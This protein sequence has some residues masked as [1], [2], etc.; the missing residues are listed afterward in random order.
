MLQN[1]APGTA[2]RWSAVAALFAAGAA[3]A[4]PPHRQAL[5]KYYGVHLAQSLHQCATCHLSKDEV[6]DP[7]EYDP[8][9]PPH[10]VFGERLARLGEEFET[11]GKPTDVAL[12][13]E[14]VANEDADGDGVPNEIEI[15]LGR[16]AGRP[17]PPPEK[18]AIEE[19]L[20]KQ[21]QLRERS[22]AYRW[23]P[24]RRVERPAIP[25][26]GAQG[27]WAANPIDAFIAEGYAAHGLAP[28]PPAPRHVLIRRAYLDL[29]GLPPTAEEVQSFAA[30]PSPDAFDRT[31]DRL[32]ASPAH[33]ERWGRH[34]MDVWRYSDW[35]GWTD[36]GQIRDSQPH[37]WRWRDWIIESLNADKG[38]D[39]MVREM[40]AGDELAPEDPAALA[41]TGFLVRNYKM[42]SRETWLQDAVE[43]TGKAFLGLTL[44]CARCHD[45]VYDPIAQEEYFQFR[46]IFEPHN[47]RLDRVPGQPD[48]KLD[49]LPRV[50]DAEPAAKTYVFVRG[51]DRNPDQ[52]R[53][54]PPGPPSCVQGGAFEVAAVPLPT[55]AYYPGLDSFVAQETLAAARARVADAQAKLT[56]AQQASSGN[57]QAESLEA[58]D[59]RAAETELASLEARLAADRVKHRAPDSAELAELSAAAARA[60]HAAQL[61]AKERDLAGA[62]RALA[63]LQQAS[64]VDEG[65]VAEA[66]K[67]RDAAAAERDRAA[68][69]APGESYSSVGPVYP[70]SSTGRRAALARWLTGRENPLAARV[71]VNHLWR[72]HFGQAI[73]AST[74]DFGQNGSPPSHP[75][76]LD[77]LAA[78]FMESSAPAASGP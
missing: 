3:F 29:V 74:F 44:N 37:I 62:E 69:Q 42:L 73:V 75:A 31:V 70:S 71:A 43:H 50:Y 48:P 36:G 38:Y 41:A 57:E 51:D 52:S 58:L 78:E 40:L 7:E 9:A 23:A 56:A 54:I 49:G 63:E 32:L 1:F 64:P 46:A 34:W 18:E 67:K 55:G 15:L 24:F 22:I 16:H 30:D 25:S 47:V 27:D 8:E 28:N 14:A 72:R 76:L 61:A 4:I 68:A 39:R 5:K 45:H 26:A 17:E 2:L 33:G 20:R 11:E 6:P 19:A 12:R 60:E 10:N 66:Q 53:E 77:W 59:F 21:E 65:K 35:A 13:L